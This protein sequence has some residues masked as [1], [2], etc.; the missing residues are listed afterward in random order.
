MVCHVTVTPRRN[1][2][3]HFLFFDTFNINGK[4][5]FYYIFV[6]NSFMVHIHFINFEEKIVSMYV[7]KKSKVG[8]NRTIFSYFPL[9]ME[10]SFFFKK[11]MFFTIHVSYKP[12]L[13]YKNISMLDKSELNYSLRDVSQSNFSKTMILTAMGS[14]GILEYTTIYN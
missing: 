6:L 11:W 14:F 8:W 1:I 13:S 9:Y 5:I 2:N 10:T 4:N 7:G 3:F 12:I